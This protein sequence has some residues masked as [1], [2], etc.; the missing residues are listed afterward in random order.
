VY[1]GRV[2]P[3]VHFTMGGVTI[4]ERS[5]VLNADEL[6]LEAF[7]QLVKLPVG[8]MVKIGSEVLLCWSV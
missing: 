6:Q 5:E 8:F 1:V 7:G 4:N 2:T 3:V